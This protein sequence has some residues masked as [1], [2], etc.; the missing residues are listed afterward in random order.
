MPSDI[1]SSISGIEE[2]VPFV[3]DEYE[4]VRKWSEGH[5]GMDRRGVFF[6]GPAE[7]IAGLDLYIGDYMRQRPFSLN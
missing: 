2:I 6:T 3:G 7:I 4:R 5:R 1:K